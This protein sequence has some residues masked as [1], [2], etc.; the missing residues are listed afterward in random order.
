MKTTQA[1]WAA[2]SLLAATSACNRQPPSPNQ[3]YLLMAEVTISGETN[4]WV[5]DS[6]LSLVDCFDAMKDKK[7]YNETIQQ[8]KVA[9]TYACTNKD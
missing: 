9:L 6:G 7:H 3:S 8:T 2:C 4:E 1:L 5:I